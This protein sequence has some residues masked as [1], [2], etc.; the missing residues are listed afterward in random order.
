MA[1]KLVWPFLHMTNTTM[2]T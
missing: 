1:T 2:Y